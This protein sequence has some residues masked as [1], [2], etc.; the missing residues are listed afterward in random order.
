M[1]IRNHIPLWETDEAMT[2]D[3]LAAALDISDEEAAEYDRREREQQEAFA[4]WL[5]TEFDE[6]DDEPDD[7]PYPVGAVVEAPDGTQYQVVCYDSVDGGY[8]LAGFDDVDEGGYITADEMS[9]F[10]IVG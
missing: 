5:A 3:E 7:R 1:S 10:A 6:A 2:D 8:V 4:N 9:N